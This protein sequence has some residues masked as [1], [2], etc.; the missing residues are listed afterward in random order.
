MNDGR[1]ALLVTALCLCGGIA[2]AA[3]PGMP[4]G[5]FD[6]WIRGRLAIVADWTRFS[7][8]DSRRLTDHGLNNK[9]RANFL[10]SLW[11]LEA[12]QH[13]FPD[14]SLEYRIV[15]VFGLGASYDQ[16]RART[17]DWGP[18]AEIVGDGD[19]EIRGAQAY[20]FGRYPNRSRVTPYARVGLARYRS[21][22]FVLPSWSGGGP[23]RAIRVDDTSGPFAAG[24]LRITVWRH[25]ALDAFYRYSFIRDVA[26]RAYGDIVNKPNQHRNGAFPMRN[27]ALGI[28]GAYGF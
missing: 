5:F 2:E 17:L 21:R 13:Y 19:V 8:A 26:A 3:S 6:H 22:F 23:G 27:R 15:S 4:S 24:G 16:R 1:F 7:L 18:H 10:G 14:P 9:N 25:A 12:R 28:G 20:V 11:G